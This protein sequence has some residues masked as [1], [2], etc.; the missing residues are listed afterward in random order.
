M[1]LDFAKALDKVNHL[2]LI[3]K[4]EHYGINSCTLKWVEKF[5]KD[6]TQ[7]V[8]L[9]GTLSDSAPVLS[10]VPQ[11]TVLGPLLFLI[12]INDLP[13]YVS[14]GTSVRLFADDSAIYRVIKSPED[15]DILQKD[16]KSLEKWEELWSMCFH[17]DKCQLIRVTKKIYPSKFD[18]TIHGVTIEKVDSAKY[19][20]V[21][22]SENMS[23]SAHITTICKKA[24]NTINF[25]YRNFKTC[26]PH[27]KAKLYI[28]YV[29]PT[30]EYCSSVW[31]PHTDSDIKKIEAVQKRA[32]RF[33]FNSYSRQI[34]V[35]PLLQSLG[36]F[37]LK[38]RRARAKVTLLFKASMKPPVVEISTNHLSKV[39]A[40][41][42]T[43]QYGNYFTPFVRTGTHIFS[44]FNSTIRL[45]NDM[46]TDAKSATS[47]S[48]FLDALASH[49]LRG[50]Y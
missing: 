2:S 13:K 31:D 43:R 41:I 16:I 10:G 27:I 42:R 14:P 9:E 25:L 38:E 22:I 47:L 18:Y 1:F 3:K 7:K 26:P 8:L 36:W 21:T 39:Q 6:R 34:R 20:G 30:L 35:T 15:H 17:P 44:F 50:L 49:T 24:H 48:L 5:L 29:R 40:N 4:M 37:P 19:L 11:G 32:A 23:W 12:Y 46:P 28:T 45:W 33:V